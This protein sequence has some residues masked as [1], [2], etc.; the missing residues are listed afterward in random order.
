MEVA[1]LTRAIVQELFR[2]EDG[3]LI[4]AVLDKH[5]KRVL[6][7]RA[8]S[9]HQGY[10]K[11]RIKGR[12]Y[13][14]HRLIWLYHHGYMPENDIDHIDRNT[15]NNRIENL[16]EVSRMCN[17]RN[18]GNQKNNTSGVNGVGWCKQTQKW[19]AYIMVMSKG[20]SIGRFS[21]FSEAVCHRL[22]AE[23][24]LNWVG[25]NT[26]SPAFLYV[27]KMIGGN[28]GRNE[29]NNGNSTGGKRAR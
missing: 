18:T 12:L 15:L 9:A 8:G 6:G 29:R 4:W 10:K 16:R 2:Y 1:M 27:Q 19:S 17:L 7:K 28:H 26:T 3:E 21:D 5:N 25:C 14:N 22:A 20:N 13:T 23:Q 24:C 11:T